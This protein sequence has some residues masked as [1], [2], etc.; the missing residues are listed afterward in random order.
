MR[1]E[2]EGTPLHPYC[3]VNTRIFEKKIMKR[4]ILT[5]TF[6]VFLLFT[7]FICPVAADESAM[8]SVPATVATTHTSV[9]EDSGDLFSGV[10]TNGNQESDPE[11]SAYLTI[12]PQNVRVNVG[13]MI[14]FTASMT[15]VDDAVPF[16]WSCS[17]ENVG[18][19]ENGV[20]TGLCAG[21][22]VVTVTAGDAMA[23]A[24]VVVCE[25]APIVEPDLSV[26][27]E[28]SVMALE[29]GWS[30]SG[31]VSDPYLINSAGD[32]ELLATNVN[33][34]NPYS[35]AYFLVTEDIDLSGYANWTS[36][37]SRNDS[38]N[39]RNPFQGVFDGDGRTISGL[40]ITD[41]SYL[42]LFGYVSN[43]AVLREVHLSVVNISSSSSNYI[44]GLAGLVDAAS[45]SV[46]IESCSASGTVS[47]GSGSGTKYVGGLVGFV[48]AG[49]SGSAIT[50]RDCY[51][52][53]DVSGSYSVGGLVGSVD[54]G[55][56]SSVITIQGCSASGEVSGS[57][58]AGGLVGHVN[59]S[60]GSGITILDCC[61]RGAVCSYLSCDVGGLVGYAYA[62]SGS[63]I[64]IQGCSA[65]GSVSG[66]E[67]VGG[68]VGYA[69]TSGSESSV[70]VRDCSASSEVDGPRTVGGLVGL[71]DAE[72]SGSVVTIQ[73]CSS[74]G[75]VSRGQHEGGGLIGK[76]Y[77]RT[78]G[79]VITIQDC[80]ST[81]EVTGSGSGGLIGLVESGNSGAVVT[82]QNCF[83]TGD[84]SDS[85]SVSGFVHSVS[86][87]SSGSV[88][89]IQNCYSSG[90]VSS[91]LENAAGLVTYVS[92]G[93]SGS[94]VSILDCYASG[95]VS[96]LI[97]RGTY[98]GLVGSVHV[99]GSGS[100]V[101]I[102]RSVSLAPSVTGNITGRIV[103]SS[104]GSGTLT[105][106]NTY[107]L[108][109]M[110]T[111]TNATDGIDVTPSDAE[112][113]S[114][115]KDT[116]GW[117]F[118]NFWKMDAAESRYPVLSVSPL[119]T[120]VPTPT[121][122]PVQPQDITTLSFKPGWNFISIP[123]MLS[124]DQNTAAV[125][126]A[127]VQ[128]GGRNIIGY[129][130]NVSG[131]VKLSD[132]DVVRPLNGYWIFSDAAVSIKLI[133]SE[134]PTVPAVKPLYPGWNAIGLSSDEPISTANA[135]TGVS[136]RTLLPW[137]VAAGKWG[138]AVINGGSGGYGA[139]RMMTT[140]NGY[141]LYVT[142]EG[143][144]TGLT[145]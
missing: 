24:D 95:P 20:F 96:G 1:V 79:S 63:D 19:I 82:I 32:L 40:T 11:L 127:N 45:G 72:T 139:E 114:F 47:E 134:N 77:A 89:T 16:V 25:A 115:Y 4:T 124:A 36:I 141:W 81:G 109:T 120:P 100:V 53:S 92:V 143:V 41:G 73:N 144:L 121:I 13:Q 71:A 9:S 94:T 133:F 107:A 108:S 83:S 68:L 111:S 69:Y 34:G 123:K 12:S 44:G 119:P 43:G 55:S 80:F 74:S 116:L 38:Q 137:N 98:S 59:A 142:E 131:W 35:G 51:S 75:K 125:L 113:Q 60:S 117:D 62:S 140:G 84:V 138:A 39:S 91:S 85:Y 87:G 103:G 97:S 2:L 8:A 112:A 29:H 56:S 10:L 48:N 37:G 93:S 28:S 17:D 105:L 86:V 30:G 135:L 26:M 3:L 46:V 5:L 6:T 145:A 118:V 21:T 76:V 90:T 54:A 66:Y 102:A 88:V 50:I 42:G 70:I 7:A 104:D 67:N 128:T 57:R 122:R 101:T 22:A 126:F 130:A 99:D 65:R 27:S 61:E 18:S 14:T 58:R 64:T 15:D 110:V 33:S 31:T 129:D 52:G 132:T 136:W 78:S 106:A 23:S 49:I